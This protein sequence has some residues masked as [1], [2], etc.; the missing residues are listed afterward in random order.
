M[1]DRE[2]ELLYGIADEVS[3]IVKEGE[4]EYCDYS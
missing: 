1:D 4:G 2:R 3:D